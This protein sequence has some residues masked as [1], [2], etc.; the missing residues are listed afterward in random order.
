MR[1]GVYIGRFQ[2]FHLGHLHVIRV[3]LKSCDRLLIL[4]GSAGGPRTVKNPW[5][6]E[7]RKGMIRA[8]LPDDLNDAVDIMPLP[9]VSGDR[10][11][12]ERV[13]FEVTRY[14]RDLNWRSPE[15]LLAG[16]SK[17][18][19]SYYLSL[20]PDWQAIEVENHGDLSATPLREFFFS[21]LTEPL[22]PEDV[23]QAV[24]D[25]AED[26]ALDIPHAFAAMQRE[27]QAVRDFVLSWRSA[28]YSPTF[29]TTDALVVHRG[30]VAV[31]QRGRFPG[32][33]LRAMPG[34]FLEPGLG[35]MANVLKEF[36]EETGDGAPAEW[37]EPFFDHVRIFDKPDRDPRGRF[38]THVFLFVLPDDFDRPELVGGDDAEWAGW[39]PLDDVR[40]SDFAF[41]HYQIITSLTAGLRRQEHLRQAA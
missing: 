35:L 2:P 28:P 30:D 27:F 11:W 31:I 40:A 3:A 29:V 14:Y 39:I 7:E 37:L 10:A 33:G 32:R 18:A 23:G 26:W 6:A 38:V 15:I 41:D 19:S 22:P 1:L 8:G 36:G 20:F 12:V 4:V 5:T 16:H 25:W 17:D 9:D 13:R 21:D 24:S 34:G